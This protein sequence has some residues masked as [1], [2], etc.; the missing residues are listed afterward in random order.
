M[1]FANANLWT[2]AEDAILLANLDLKEG[3]LSALIPGRSPASCSSRRLKL[4]RDVTPPPPAEPPPLKVRH[5]DYD[6]LSLTA[7]ICGDPPVQRSALWQKQQ[8]G[9]QHG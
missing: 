2:A 7:R 9:P 6:G 4:K 1:T 3:E 5:E 8:G